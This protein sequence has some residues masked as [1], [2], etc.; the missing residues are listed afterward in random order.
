[1]IKLNK[2]LCWICVAKTRVNVYFTPKGLSEHQD[3][4]HWREIGNILN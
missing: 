1:M 2:L 3:K 4:V